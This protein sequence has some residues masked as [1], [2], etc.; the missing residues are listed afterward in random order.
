VL[1]F[2]NRSKCRQVLT[3]CCVSREFVGA[4][5]D[6]AKERVPIDEEAL[7]QGKRDLSP[8][9][10]CV[11]D[12]RDPFTDWEIPDR[13][14]VEFSFSGPTGDAGKSILRV[15]LAPKPTACLDF[16]LD[17][18][19]V[20]G[21]ARPDLH[22]LGASFAFDFVAEEDWPVHQEGAGDQ[23]QPHEFASFNRP[24]Y[25]P[26]DA[27]VAAAECDQADLPCTPGGPPTFHNG[28]PPGQAKTVV[29]GNY[30][31]LQLRD[32]TCV[33]MGH[34]KRASLLVQVGQRVAAGQPIGSTGNSGNTSGA[35][36][37]IEMLDGVPDLAHA[38]TMEFGHS[39]IPFGFRNLSRPS[40]DDAQEELVVPTKEEVVERVGR[41]QDLSPPL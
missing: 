18:R 30:V 1:A 21:N 26:A 24:L 35:H 3:D 39:G 32:E 38:G 4:R 6:Q 28:A 5:Q 16:P 14:A 29:L 8:G 41:R 25:S 19:W 15:P 34:L 9:D 22:G 23:L 12:V 40:A 7:T 17:G 37:H 36:L 11:L 20:A 27:V 10:A 31:A 33:F 2:V 13:L